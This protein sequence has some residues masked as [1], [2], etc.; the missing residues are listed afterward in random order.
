MADLAI[1]DRC[2]A[3]SRQGG[4]G[5]DGEETVAVNVRCLEDVDLDA[6]ERKPVDGRSF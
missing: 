4:K 5:K 2:D 1:I 3:A 6:I